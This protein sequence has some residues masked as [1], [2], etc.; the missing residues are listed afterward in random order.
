MGTYLITGASKGIGFQTARYLAS[1]GHIVH[2]AA[3]NVWQMESLKASYPQHIV[4]HKL[5]LESSDSIQNLATVLRHTS[6]NGLVNNAGLLINKP[7]DELDAQDWRRTFEVNLFGQ[8]ELTRKLKPCFSKGSH[9]VNISSMGGFQGSSKF[10][11]LSA[12]SAAKGALSIL[13]E[14]LSAEW[15]SEHIIVN[16]LCLGAVQTEMLEAAFPGYQAPVSAGE[17]GEFIGTFLLNAHK[18]M[19]GK[20]LPLSLNDPG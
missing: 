11:G 20:I 18:V 17:M 16:A 9:I 2:I 5:D 19:N 14:C 1:K 8:V 6:L 12:Y 4:T 3:R 15:S 13:T 7:F 10:P